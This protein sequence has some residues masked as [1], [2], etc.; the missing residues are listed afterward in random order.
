MIFCERAYVRTY[1]R[2]PPIAK[3]IRPPLRTYLPDELEKIIEN[4]ENRFHGASFGIIRTV[5]TY[6]RTY[7]PVESPSSGGIWA[8]W[9]AQA[10]EGPQ[11]FP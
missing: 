7:M 9:R 6:E 3:P 2:Q 5:R 4:E 11:K 10:K 8:L 1:I